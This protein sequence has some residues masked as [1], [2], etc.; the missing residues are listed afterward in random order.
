MGYPQGGYPRS[1]PFFGSKPSPE[2]L[3]NLLCRGNETDVTQCNKTAIENPM[4]GVDGY[5]VGGVA[6]RINKTG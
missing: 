4:K 2:N 1:T 5:P 6:C 3:L